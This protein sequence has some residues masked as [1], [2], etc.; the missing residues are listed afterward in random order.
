MELFSDENIK[1]TKEKYHHKLL[2]FEDKDVYKE[3]LNLLCIYEWVKRYNKDNKFTRNEL[4]GLLKKVKEVKEPEYYKLYKKM[5]P[6]IEFYYND[7]F[8]INNMSLIIKPVIKDIDNRMWDVLRN[9]FSTMP[10]NSVVGNRSKYFV[11]DENS[12]NVLGVIQLSSPQLFISMRDYYFS[13]DRNKIKSYNA[14]ESIPNISICVPTYPFSL[15]LGGKLCAM[16]S[17]SK[18]VISFYE[19]KMKDNSN[20]VNVYTTSLYGESIQYDRLKEFKFI[21]LSSGFTSLPYSSINLGKI[22]RYI[23]G[24]YDK[25]TCNVGMMVM[26]T[27]LKFFNV[28]FLDLGMNRGVY[29]GNLCKK[30]IFD[31]EKFDLK[32]YKK[33]NYHSFDEKFDYWSKRWFVKRKDRY[34]SSFIT[35]EIKD[36]LRYIYSRF[37]ID[38]KIQGLTFFNKKRGKYQG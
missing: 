19:S 35:K 26:S 37:N 21:G 25:I 31:D 28:K 9:V 17:L 6:Y 5:L 11:Y 12:D 23:G 20:I 32:S 36:K 22:F 24:N 16:S 30:K 4:M 7:S 34:S 2:F 33:I 8:D 38:K 13:D 27:I 14:F 10:N 18:E 1:Y 29:V 3:V 15:F